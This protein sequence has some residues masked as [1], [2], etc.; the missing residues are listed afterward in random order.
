[1]AQLQKGTTFIDGGTYAAASLN[2]HVDQ[3]IVLP[4][5]IS[6]QTN[7]TNNNNNDKIF[8]LDGGTGFLKNMNRSDFLKN[9][10]D[11]KETLAQ[12]SHGFVSGDVLK[13][14]GSTYAKAQGDTLDN[15]K[16]V[17]IV[18]S[19][20][21]S[22]NFV[23]VRSG[24]MLKSSHGFTGGAWLYL[25]PTSAGALTTTL[26][27]LITYPS[28]VVC[29]TSIDANYLFVCISDSPGILDSQVTEIKLDELVRKEQHD[30][31]TTAGTTTA[32]TLTPSPAFTS[33]TEGMVIRFTPNAANLVGPVTINVNALGAKTIKKWSRLAV[34]T[35]AELEANDLLTTGLYEATYTAAGT[36]LLK[37]V[38]SPRIR[39]SQPVIILQHQ[40]TSGTS[41]GTF[42]SGSFQTRPLTTEVVDTHNLCTIATNQFTLQPG[43]YLI[44]ARAIANTVNRNQMRIQN[45][46]DTS[47]VAIGEVNNNAASIGWASQV[48]GYVSIATAKTYE[49]QHRCETTRATDGFGLAFSVTTEVYAT[50]TIRQLAPP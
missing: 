50:V 13:L 11:S 29:A 4:G 23:F 6:E 37:D 14:S 42:T 16:P 41:G 7:S 2:N 32:Y 19:V 3:A 26:P 15:A 27:S 5:V 9:F 31:G 18:E 45:I 30:Y 34:N 22:N 33:Y 24:K 12:A 28:Y 46:T 20:V 39:D 10:T 47:T 25:S 21:D 8:M 43:T 35:I 17:G 38:S 36:F 40:A 1:M 49:I 44:K 48:D